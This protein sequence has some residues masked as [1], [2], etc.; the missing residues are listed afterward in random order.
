MKKK[1]FWAKYFTDLNDPRLST[2]NCLCVIVLSLSMVMAGSGDLE[3][4]RTCRYLKSRIGGNLQHVTYGSQMAIS[5]ALSL[6]FMGGGRYSLKTD[7]LSVALMLCA[8]YPHF[9]VDSNDNRFHLQAFRHLYVLASEP[10]LLL[11]K[12]VE[13]GEFCYVPVEITLR[14]NEHHG[15]FKFE[16]MAP[17]IL[18]ELNRIGELRILGPRHYP[19]R[20]KHSLD[21][22]ELRNILMTELLVKQ[23]NGYFSYA[24]DPKDEK[25][26]NIRN[27]LNKA[28]IPHRITPQLLEQITNEEH[29]NL[30]A[31]M[32]N[33][34][35]GNENKLD[36]KIN[37]LL[38]LIYESVVQETFDFV[39]V[40]LLLDEEA[41][42]EASSH[43]IQQ[44]KLLN[45]F[46]KNLAV[47]SSR[48]IIL[49]QE[50][51]HFLLSSLETKLNDR[52]KS[53][54]SFFL[55]FFFE[56]ENYY[57]LCLVVKNTASWS[58]AI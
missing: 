25:A 16:Q 24:D 26:F 13:T 5:M 7:S 49:T 40:M 10:R 43:F 9:P 52:I 47:K 50:F 19:I 51:M 4:F 14:A 32:L 21:F 55:T 8:F 3:V 31:K 1:L 30:F 34:P 27:F 46:Y 15:A 37:R 20:F 44:I 35:T 41:N 54:N 23:R 28:I 33:K 45:G 2:E 29:V 57:F 11:S 58:S 39:G 48:H 42:G 56:F 18:P 36:S 38:K 17:C 22:D 12:N 6:L 53:N